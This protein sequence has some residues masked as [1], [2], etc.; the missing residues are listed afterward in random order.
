[1]KKILFVIHNMEDGGA[2]KVLTSLVN[3]MSRE[4]FD[5][6][7]VSL[8]GGGVNE[9]LLKP[10]IHYRAVFPRPFRGNSI[11]QKL[12]S[13]EFL[14]RFCIREHYDIEVS[15]LEG[16][17]ARIVSGCRDEN[18]RLVCWIHS[19]LQSSR[20]GASCFRSVKEAQSCYSR[21]ERIICVSKWTQQA[22]R[23]AFPAIPKVDVLYNTVESDLILSSARQEAARM[24]ASAGEFKLIG[25]GSLKPVKGFDRLIRVHARLRQ[26]GYP[27]HTYLL[28]QGPDLEKLQQQAADCGEE[29][30]VTFL[31][32]DPNPCQYVQKSDLFVCSSHSEGFSTAV[33]EALIVGTPICTVHVSGM[34]EMLGEN[35]EWGIVTENNEEALYQGIRRLLD[36]PSLLKSYREKAARRGKVFST[37]N[38]VHAV[39]EMLL[40]L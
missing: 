36:D 8:F 13:P 26:E 38:T 4:Q 35:D 20:D 29:A 27:V 19:T 37:G 1:M 40:S 12:F 7:V 39:E 5:I 34:K 30:S 11:I 25:V 10:H 3:N 17:S 31:G 2:Q 16:V 23:N 32:F 24:H 21:F 28:G 18:T 9:Q 15:Y 6:S 33:T 14:H 22:F